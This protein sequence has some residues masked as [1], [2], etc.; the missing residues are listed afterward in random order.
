[1]ISLV[2]E[3]IRI[4]EGFF[5]NRYIGDTRM[6]CMSAQMIGQALSDILSKD[7]NPSQA[8][9]IESAY[10][11]IRG[12]GDEKDLGTLSFNKCALRISDFMADEFGME[13]T[14]KMIIEAIDRDP[15]RLL[16][17]MRLIGR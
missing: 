16:R 14:L 2:N 4:E 11:W 15:E 6:L 10:A 8:E 12:E 13:I 5:Q 17:L 3:T 1:M 7:K 9:Y